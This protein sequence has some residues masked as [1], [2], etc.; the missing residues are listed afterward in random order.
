MKL[1]PTIPNWNSAPPEVWRRWQLARLRDYLRTRVVPFSAHYGRMFK[2]H[3]I[4][5]LD[6]KSLDDWSRVPFTSKQDLANSRDF[7]LMPD[8]AVLQRE[9]GMIFT[10]LLHGRQQQV[11]ALHMLRLQRAAGQQLKVQFGV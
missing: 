5:P 7:V 2:A 11:A 9:T 3:G 4:H 1:L 8:A 6:L 10:A